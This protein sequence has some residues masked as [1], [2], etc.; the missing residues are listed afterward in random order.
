M[1]LNLPWPW[2]LNAPGRILRSITAGMLVLAAGP[3]PA[4]SIEAI[5]FATF[6]GKIYLP[7]PEVGKELKWRFRQDRQNVTL[8][9][10][11]LDPAGLRWLPDG[12]PLVSADELK[13]AGAAVETNA[14]GHTRIL[15]GRGDFTIATGRKRVRVSLARQQLSAWQGSRLV[16]SSR[17][18][19]G[20]HGSTPAGDFTAGPYKARMHYSSLYQNAPMPWSVQIHRNVFIHGFTSVPPYPASHGCIRL[21]LTGGNPARFFYQWIDCGTP[22]KVTRQ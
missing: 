6:P 7:V 2:N 4:E 15:A 10:K 13:H 22:V 1:D 8:N 11:T 20:R 19:S 17:I 5:T 12:T 3:A 9:R 16:M 18:S 14:Q 21:P